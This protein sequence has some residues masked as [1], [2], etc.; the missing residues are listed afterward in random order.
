VTTKT[1]SVSLGRAR[2][3]KALAE[4]LQALPPGL[5]G[6]TVAFIVLAHTGGLDVRQLVAASTELHRLGVL[7]NQS[8]RV[9]AGRGV[10]V[11]TLH[12]AVGKIALLFPCHSK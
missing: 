4:Q 1:A 8:L 10:D 7:L 3:P 2:L 12:E 6:R 9:S 11:P 5:R